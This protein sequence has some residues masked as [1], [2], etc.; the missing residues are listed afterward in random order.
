MAIRNLRSLLLMNSGRAAVLSKHGTFILEYVPVLGSVN[1]VRHH[2]IASSRRNHAVTI[3]ILRPPHIFKG[4]SNVKGKHF[5][6]FSEVRLASTFVVEAPGKLSDAVSGQEPAVAGSVTTSSVVTDPIPEPPSIPSVEATTDAINSASETTFASL[7]LGGWTPV[8]I[9]ENCME[10]LHV[11]CGIPWWASIALGTLVVR[12]LLFPVVI[13]SQ[14]NAAKMNNN[15]P[16][17]QVLQL[18]MTEAR[19]TGNHIEAARYAQELMLF[20]KEKKLNPLKNMLVPLAQAPIFISFFMAL[21]G[22]ANIPI[23]DMVTGGLWWFTDLTMPDQYF[24]LPL[25]TSA[26]LYV[27]IE[28]GTDSARLNSQNM[29]VMKYVLRALPICIFPFTVNFPGA[30]LCYWLS[31]NVIS[32]IQVGL[33]RVPAVRELAKIEPLIRHDPDSLPSKPKGFVEGFKD[34]FTNMKITRE[35]EERERY[36]EMQFRR[37]GTA[38]LRKT[39]KYDPTL[40]SNAVSAKKRST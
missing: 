1:N 27:T 19:Q 4:T 7:G 40:P 29:H 16:Q 20:M 35:M 9:V 2:H 6:S 33:L 13:A 26:T 15:L 37:A 32:L 8:G 17:M 23:P 28:V 21:R 30:V 25:L 39:F 11:D 3:N 36:D 31:S 5:L 22:M 12:V 24:L 10:F 18:R 34:S 38:P 14:R